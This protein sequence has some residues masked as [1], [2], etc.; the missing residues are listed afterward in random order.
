MKQPRTKAI[1]FR[2]T[3]EEWKELDKAAKRD[4]DARTLSEFVRRCAL[5]RARDKA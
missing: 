1:I 3:D 5:A 2:V 4:T